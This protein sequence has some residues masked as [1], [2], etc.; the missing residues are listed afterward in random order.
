MAGIYSGGSL[1]T[2]LERVQSFTTKPPGGSD[3]DMRPGWAANST[4][5]LGHVYAPMLD[6][7][8]RVP[9]GRAG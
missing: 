5:S 3:G 8:M 1:K 4:I 6:R 9:G 7:A 2:D